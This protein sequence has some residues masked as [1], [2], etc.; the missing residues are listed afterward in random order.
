MYA[1][2]DLLGL[3][4]GACIVKHLIA[5]VYSYQQGYA[6]IGFCRLNKPATGGA[7]DIQHALKDRRVG[8]LRKH[9]AHAF[10]NHLVEDF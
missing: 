2:T 1:V 7:A 3:C 10:G 8:L 6:R 9:A 5:D 4:L